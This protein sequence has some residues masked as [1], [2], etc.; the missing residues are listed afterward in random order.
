[1]SKDTIVGLTKHGIPI[2]Q[3]TIKLKKRRKRRAKASAPQSLQ[4]ERE[5][6]RVRNATRKFAK[7]FLIEHKDICECCGIK[8]FTLTK[9]HPDYSQPLLVQWLCEE[10]HNELHKKRSG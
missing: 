5:H 2:L 7:A 6:R 10:C 9:H 3:P 4:I 1:M 8:K